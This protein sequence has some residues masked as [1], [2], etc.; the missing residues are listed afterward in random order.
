M[1]TNITS[2][3]FLSETNSCKQ[4]SLIQEI[5]INKGNEGLEHFTF[6]SFKL[7][8]QTDLNTKVQQIKTDYS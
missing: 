8:I 6:Y 7:N 2:R 1:V 4:N 5:N 3:Q